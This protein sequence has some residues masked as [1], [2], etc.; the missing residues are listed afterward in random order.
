[1]PAPGGAP[2]RNPGLPWLVGAGASG[3]RYLA[4]SYLPTTAGRS[5]AETLPSHKRYTE[6]HMLEILL[7]IAQKVCADGP[8]SNYPLDARIELLIVLFKVVRYA[9]RYIKD[10]IH[11]LILQ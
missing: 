11:W 4:D 2:G 6:H 8:A 1:M 9:E 5:Q 10:T 3:I 7:P